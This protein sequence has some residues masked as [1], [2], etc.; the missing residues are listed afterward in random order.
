M[1]LGSNILQEIIDLKRADALIDATRI[2]EI[3]SQQLSNDFLRADAQL[4][5]VF[6]LFGRPAVPRLGEPI[7][8]G[9][10]G[11]LELQS[12]NAPPS[13][14]FWEALGFHYATIDF[15]GHRHSYPLDLNKDSVPR[16][17]RNNFD[18]AIN[19][20]T[21]EHLA[22]Q[23]NAFRVIHDLVRK[24]GIMIHELPAGG[25]PTHGLI[26]YTMKFFWHLCRENRYQVL[27]L[28]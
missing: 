27:R 8:V 1:G 2:V 17:W 10:L 16:H 5:E 4:K 14:L 6:E 21:T 25:M 11:G 7:A 3:G 28:R 13:Q 18:L 22:N 26:T 9:Y 12:A 20:G 15:D 24:G 19:A 23:D